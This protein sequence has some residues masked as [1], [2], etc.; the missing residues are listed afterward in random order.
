MSYFSRLNELHPIRK[1]KAQKKAFR[2]WAMGEMTALG[3]APQVEQN[4]KGKHQNIIAGDPEHAQLVI[5]AHYDTPA[6]WLADVQIPR[7]F[8]AYVLYQMLVIGGMLLVSFIGG[9]AAGLIAQNGNVMIMT[10][11]GVFVALMMLQLYGPA[12]RHNANDNTSGVA[13][14]LETMA[15]IPEDKRDKA[16]FILFDNSASGRRGAKAYGRD[17]IELQHTRLVVSLDHVGVGDHILVIST[18]LAKNLTEFDMLKSCLVSGGGREVHHFS[19][20]TTR[21]GGDFR[22]FKCGVGVMACEKTGGIG[23]YLGDLHTPRD[24]HCDEGNLLHLAQ[25]LSETVINL[26]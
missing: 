7:N 5:T 23:F 21:C 9:T 10:F 11:L 17:H 22:A 20:A 1:A 6:R 26:P 25:G 13:A 8:P 15:R 24:V 4:D 16:A 12:N 18:A 19:S 14:L 3:Y 2:T